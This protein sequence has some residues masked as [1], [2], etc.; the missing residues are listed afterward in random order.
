MIVTRTPRSRNQRASH[1]IIGV[2]PVPPSVRLPTLMTG[3]PTCS[4]GRRPQSYLRF[5]QRTAQV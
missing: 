5:R 2:L 4:T 3:I 1:S